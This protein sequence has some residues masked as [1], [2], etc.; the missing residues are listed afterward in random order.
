MGGS[1]FSVVDIYDITIIKSHQIFKFSKFQ[2]YS[3]IKFS[4]FLTLNIQENWIG[5]V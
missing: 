3:K 5:P 4:E 2:K 1:N